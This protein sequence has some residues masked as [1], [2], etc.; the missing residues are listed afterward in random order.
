MVSFAL[1]IKTFSFC[2]F[3]FF[4]VLAYACLL[5]TN[6]DKTQLK[7]IM[8]GA[9]VSLI[10]TFQITILGTVFFI[11]AYLIAYYWEKFS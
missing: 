1:A 10:H 6:R 3:V 9:A 2:I 4:F 5:W 11:L 8:T 7:N